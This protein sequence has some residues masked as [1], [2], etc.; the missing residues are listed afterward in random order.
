M[1]KSII[2]NNIGARLLFEAISSSKVPLII[3]NGYLG[4]LKLRLNY[5]NTKL[6]KDFCSLKRPYAF[7]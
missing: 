4:S 5:F 3:H 1:E 6:N 2:K 7:I